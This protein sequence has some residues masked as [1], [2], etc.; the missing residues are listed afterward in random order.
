MILRRSLKRI[1][2]SSLVLFLLLMIYLLPN[3]SNEYNIDSTI[4]YV[5]NDLKTH[6]IFLLDNNNYLGQTNIIIKSENQKELAYELIETL[7]IDGKY[8]DKIPNGFKAIIPESTKIN[9]IEIQNNLIKIDFNDALLD[10]SKELEEKIIEAI[11]FNL[12]SIENINQV[13]IYINGKLLNY[14]P[15]NK[16][17]LKNVLSREYGIN[18]EYNIN[19]KENITKTTIYYVG[20]FNDTTYYIPVTKITNENQKKMNIIVEE[21]RNSSNLSSYLNYNTKLINSEI[22]DNTI[23]VDFNDYILTDID[24]MEVSKEVVDTLTMSIY[25]NYNI[26]EIIYQVNGQDFLKIKEK[27][28][29]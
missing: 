8:Q 10:T 27:S 16:I 7:I 19:K 3:D 28:I 26:D 4:E 6:E 23:T 9:S 13:I 17:T 15:Q 21:L 11:I 14:L 18:K 5:N 20:N 22:K 29:E 2:L 12:T 25:D 1:C 24:T